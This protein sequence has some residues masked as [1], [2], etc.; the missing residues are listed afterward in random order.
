[1]GQTIDL[2]TTQSANTDESVE[3]PSARA[4]RLK[5][6]REERRAQI[7]EALQS[8]STPELL[9]AVLQAQQGRVATYREYEK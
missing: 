5:E 8:M 3:D 1:M 2:M 9:K 4:Q 6:E 7:Q